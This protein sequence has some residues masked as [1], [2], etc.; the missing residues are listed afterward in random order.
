MA[1]L[2]Q[3]NGKFRLVF[4]FN[5]QKFSR[6]IETESESAA[7]TLKG[8]LEQRLKLIKT[9]MVPPPSENDDIA[10]YLIHGRS[11]PASTKTERLPDHLSVTELGELFFSSFLKS[12]IEEGSF[13]MMQIHRRN[14]NRHLGKAS[15]SKLSQSTVQRYIARRAKDNG[16]RGQKVAPVTIRKEVT[17]LRTMLRWAKAEGLTGSLF[18]SKG[19][20]YPK[21]KEKPPFQTLGEIRRQ[22]AENELSEIEIGELWDSLFLSTSQVE[23][24]L[25]YA[26]KNQKYSFV[27][28][29]MAFAAYTGARR[30]EM[31]RS[32]LEDIDMQNK[33]IVLREKKRVRGKTSSRRIPM[34]DKLYLI[35]N[36]W[37]QEH[38][39]G[40]F[41][42]CFRHSES[43]R[44]S[45]TNGQQVTLNEAHKKF[46]S[47]LKG[48][49][50]QDIRGWHC[51]RHSFCSNC[52][53]AGV[54]Q[55]VINS[56]VGHQTEEMVRRYRHLFPHHEKEAIDSVFS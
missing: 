53:A 11:V 23:S 2:E 24:L 29:M 19:L 4:R 6:T 43:S 50:W 39:G 48:S 22:L 32:R 14:L 47:T 44:K 27:Y 18:E 55:R 20:R 35:L 9:K 12:S 3:R 26:Q 49:E 21:G 17:T 10:E 5:G 54:E 30:S 52:A 42:F 25:S 51:L 1:S 56:W 34:S 37:F 38:P 41:T 31:I 40:N 7:V 36:D 46:K 45:R 13:R 33:R 28:P 16:I 8:S 15:V